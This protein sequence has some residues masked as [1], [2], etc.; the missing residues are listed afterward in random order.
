LSTCLRESSS[1]ST[2]KK[3]KDFAGIGWDVGFDPAPL[4][5]RSWSFCAFSAEFPPATKIKNGLDLHVDFG[6]FV[7]AMDFIELKKQLH[8]LY[9]GFENEVGQ[10]RRDAVCGRGCSYCC[11]SMGNVDITTLE[12][13]IIREHI[14]SLPVP[15]RSDLVRRITG[16]KQ[17]KEKGGKPACPFQDDHGACLIYEFRPFCCRQLYSLRKCDQNGPLIHRAAVLAARKTVRRIQ[18]LD[19]TGYS[20]HISYILFLLDNLN[21]RKVYMAGSFKPDKISKFGKAHGVIIN[22]YAK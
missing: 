17:E 11:T 6:I 14:R 1:N 8:T 18:A 9:D 3:I 22:R 4:L 21:F 15:M 20:G 10:Y 13:W 16:N 7:K 5:A 12:G 2:E 19:A